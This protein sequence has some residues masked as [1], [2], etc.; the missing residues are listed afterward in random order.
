VERDALVLEA[1]GKDGAVGW[2][3]GFAIALEGACD[4]ALLSI[5]G[6]AGVFAEQVYA[7]G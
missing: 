5:D 7:I 6:H 3:E 2:G 4:A 1:G